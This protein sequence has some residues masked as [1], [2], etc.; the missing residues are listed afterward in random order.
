MRRDRVDR[1]T[2]VLRTTANAFLCL[3]QVIDVGVGAKP[4]C[5]GSAVIELRRDA[6]EE[7]AIDAVRPQQAHLLLEWLAGPSRLGPELPVHHG[8]VGMDEILPRQIPAAECNPRLIDEV[9]LAIRAGPPHMRGDRVDNGLELLL[10]IGLYL[11]GLLAILDI[12]IRAIPALDVVRGI[13]QW[14]RAEQEPPVY[15]IESPEA[16]FR[17]ASLHVCQQAPPR[18][19]QRRDIVGMYRGTPAPVQRIP[20]LKPDIVQETLV[21]ELGRP[22]WTSSPRQYRDRI[23]GDAHGPLGAAEAFLRLLAFLDVDIDADPFCYISACIS[24]RFRP[25]QEPTAASVAGYQA[26]LELE[27]LAG[28]DGSVP[29][30]I[31]FNAFVRMDDGVPVNAGARVFQPPAVEEHIRAIGATGPHMDWHRIDQSAK[32]CL[33]RMVQQ[34]LQM[35]G[36]LVVQRRG[37]WVERLARRHSPILDGV[38][39]QFDC[40][41]QGNFVVHSRVRHDAPATG[42]SVARQN[43]P[44]GWGLKLG[45]A[46]LRMK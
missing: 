21:H 10:G 12:D 13:E 6:G 3:L 37:V 14:V 2:Q 44:S 30:C 45:G 11:L 24:Q 46:A 18:F 36:R 23:E 1:I 27:R 40:R 34:M 29:G 28:A 4:S 41:A 35:L 20:Q 38:A 8:I 22:V 31:V 43:S 15:A 9:V 5:D 33:G 19:Q 7:P 32:C 16:H 17:L 25:A 39:Q 26:L 42:Y